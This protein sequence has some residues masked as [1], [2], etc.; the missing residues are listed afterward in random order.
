[1]FF[2]DSYQALRRGER[3]LAIRYAT[4]SVIILVLIGLPVGYFMLR[5]FER[6]ITFHPERAPWNGSWQVPEG[7]EDVW[8]NSADGSRLHGWFFRAPDQKPTATVIY[9]HGNGGNVSFVEWVGV[10][11]ARRGF[12]V[13]LFDYRGYGRSEGEVSDERG[14]YQDADAAYD[15]VL[16]ERGASPHTLVFYGQSLGTAVACDLAARSPCGAVILESGL[17]SAGDMAG[18]ILPW[19][20]RFLRGVTRNKFDSARKLADVKCPVLVVHGDRDEVIPVAQGHALYA[21]ANEPKRQLIVEGAGHNNVT[22]VGGSKYLDS[23]AEFVRS[24]IRL[25]AQ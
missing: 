16:R 3:R 14:L 13:L 9:F 22:I 11:L 6:A 2:T 17:S 8:F 1:M 12:D 24:A 25:D 21:A 20:P 5:R 10:N 7:G 23:L 15:Y 4:L 19:L 18:T